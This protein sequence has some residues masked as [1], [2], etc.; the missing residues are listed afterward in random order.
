MSRIIK[1][2]QALADMDSI[3]L[4]IAADNSEAADKCID[5]IEERCRTLAKYPL[6]SQSRDDIVPDLRYLIVD[7]YLVFYFPLDDGIDIVRVLH[8]ARDVEHLL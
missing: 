4:F 6:I 3:W 7:S 5:K 8:G 2:A 1:R